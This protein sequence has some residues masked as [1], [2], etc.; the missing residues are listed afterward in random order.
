MTQRIETVIPLPDHSPSH[1]SLSPS[2]GKPIKTYPS[3]PATLEHTR[4]LSLRPPSRAEALSLIRQGALAARLMF[5]AVTNS[6]CVSRTRDRGPYH[7]TT[8]V[9]KASR[10]HSRLRGGASPPLRS[11]FVSRLQGAPWRP[12]RRSIAGPE[13]APHVPLSGPD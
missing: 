4:R 5:A 9:F 12:S 13:H 3:A 2:S 8:L 1:F 11:K 7:A 6:L 10:V